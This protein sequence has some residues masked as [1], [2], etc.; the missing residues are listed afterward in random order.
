MRKIGTEGLTGA[1]GYAIIAPVAKEILAKK[2]RL[3]A[4]LSW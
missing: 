4:W 2:S 1:Q 3:V